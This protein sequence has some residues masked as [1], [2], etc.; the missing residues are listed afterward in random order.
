MPLA[1]FANWRYELHCIAAQHC[2]F[3]SPAYSS[4]TDRGRHGTE[5]QPM[6]PPLPGVLRASPS[7]NGRQGLLSR[8]GRSA[9][10][11]QMKGTAAR[12]ARG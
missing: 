3:V 1:G 8:S 2:S 11:G 9:A 7:P 10:A 4:R 12:P 5:A 6:Q